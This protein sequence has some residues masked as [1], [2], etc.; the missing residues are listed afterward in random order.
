[1]KNAIWKVMS[2]GQIV[3]DHFAGTF[4]TGKACMWLLMYHHFVVCRISTL[5]FK[6]SLLLIVEVFGTQILNEESYVVSEMDVQA[7]AKVLVSAIGNIG[8]G[9]KKLLRDSWHHLC[10]TQSFQAHI[11]PFPSITWEAPCVTT[12]GKIF[13]HHNAWTNDGEV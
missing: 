5:Y 9:R 10:R 6:E 7:A 1:M 11:R 8:T 12:W 4:N 2:S 13:C 3:V